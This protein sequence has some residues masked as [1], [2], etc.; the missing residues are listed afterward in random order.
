MAIFLASE[1]V[2][3]QRYASLGVFELDER[4]LKSYRDVMMIYHA[5]SPHLISIE[6]SIIKTGRLMNFYEREGL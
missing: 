3:L 6:C 4:S 1:P 2:F 5:V